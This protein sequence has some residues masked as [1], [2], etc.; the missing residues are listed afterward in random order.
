[1]AYQSLTSIGILSSDENN[2]T[3]HIT[4]EIFLKLDYEVI[5]K[6][7]KET[8][9]ILSSKNKL[10]LI[11]ELN[12]KIIESVLNME[13]YFDVL[14]LSTLK[15]EDYKNPFIRSMVSRGQYIIMNIDESNSMYI[16]GENTE[17]LIIT[18][19]LNKKATITASSLNTSSN[20]EFNLCLQRE[21]NSIN[22][23]KIEPM[24]VP[25][26]I[27]LIGKTSIYHGLGAIACGLSC[28]INVSQIQEVLS[29]I[30]GVYRH[31]EKIYDKNY[32]ILD[33]DCS[34]PSDYNLIFEE[35]QNIKCKDVYVISGIDIDQGIYTI[36]KNLEVILS[37][38]P[39]IGIK[40]VFLYVNKVD[41]LIRNN[42]DLLLTSKKVNYEIFTELN[43]C[44]ENTILLLDKNDLLLMMGNE[45]LRNSREI[46]S[47]LI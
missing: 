19:G 31:L 29:K 3:H 26:V 20:T 16:L 41:S 8:I 35:I 38:M 24:E 2:I 17:G 39:I 34:M 15:E 11:M 5:Y 9:N 22:G 32:M 1:M 40:K 13:L 10:V 7:K 46:I 25:I 30:S 27:N 37:W 36:K 23:I 47:Q 6:N 43:I 42:I 4:K 44:I 14:L 21:F 33:N 12:P 18:Y 28:G 45:C